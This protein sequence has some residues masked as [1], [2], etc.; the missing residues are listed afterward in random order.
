MKISLKWLSDWIEI[1]D[2]VQD[3]ERLVQLLTSAGFEVEGVHSEAEP[4]K[5]VVM[6][7][8]LEVGAHPN[9][10][11]LTVC[12]VDVGESAARQIVCGAKN[13]RT[14]DSVVVALPGAV[15]PGNFAIK[16]GE[17]RG[18]KS[19]G[20]LCSLA[21][22]GLEPD[23]TDGILIAK[24]DIN[25]GLP[26][27]EWKG[28]DDTVFE[29]KVTPNRV[30]VLSHL[31]L[32]RE[33]SLLLDRPL[34]RVEETVT[35]QVEEPSRL[36]VR[37][38]ASGESE[39]F[40]A[41]EFQ[42]VKVKESPDWMKKRLQSVGQKSINNV[43]DLTN[44]LM[45]DIGQPFHAYDKERVSKKVLNVRY[46][47]GSESL[48]LL[49]QTEIVFEAPAGDE[50]SVL[51]I[52]D[53]DRP[54]ALAGVMG[55]LESSIT[56]ET[57]AIYLE[58]AHFEQRR[59]RR[60][61]RRF[62]LSSESSLRFG[63][64]A[65]QAQSVEFALRRA[66]QLLLKVV[67]PGN[68]G[69][70][71]R[72]YR[73]CVARAEQS[74]FRSFEPRRTNLEYSHLEQRL[75][76]LPDFEIL[77]RILEGVSDEV[78]F[79]EHEISLVAKSFRRDLIEP[80]DYIEEIARVWGYDNIPETLPPL[81]HKPGPHGK[82]YAD[83]RELEE[84]LM[85]C[86]F[87][88]TVHYA[89]V[90]SKR[91]AELMGSA[92]SESWVYLQNPMSEDLNV[93]RPTLLLSLFE[94]VCENYRRSNLKGHLFE[95]APVHSKV[96]AVD[97]DSPY[98]ES[99]R[100]G[101]VSF[102]DPGGLH[103]GAD[104]LHELKARVEMLL[105]ALAVSQFSWSDKPLPNL[106]A[107][108]LLHPYQQASLTVEGRTVGG[109]F[110]VHP[111]RL[112]SEKVRVPVVMGEID[113][114]AVMQRHPRKIKFTRW[115]KNQPVDRDMAFVLPKGKLVAPILTEIRKLAPKGSKVDVF[116]ADVFEG[117]PLKDGDKSVTVAM[118]ISTDDASFQA[119]A[120]VE[121]VKSSVT[122]RFGIERR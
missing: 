107:S 55:G 53:G 48:R 40:C 80:E 3:Q 11:K 35:P 13:H 62:G 23:G 36:S 14:G 27:S 41:Q 105:K 87:S 60:T 29:I 65:V 116:V 78:E 70:A 1:E 59:I 54:V 81:A 121:S 83:S 88:Q 68:Q 84:I 49:D 33:L 22:L 6:G 115:P 44:Y 99:L 103:K 7:R 120:W 94:T 16:E 111:S 37:I 113:I 97:S 75:G 5:N 45:L 21:E 8:L 34:Q 47:K 18:Q 42:N 96:S 61:S 4:Y 46:A 56:S 38:E 2:L 79:K 25:P 85:R 17:I 30:D 39:I 82:I 122:Q 15:L 86:G 31:G 106:N 32:A 104:L 114:Q 108:T 76:A 77:K 64:G 50:D 90:S 98:A 43:V 52:A 112:E 28:F 117:A 95:I 91:L 19:S 12:S 67:P 93:M 24:G 9:A 118:R 89:F 102:G 57:Q 26:F 20:M 109:I 92:N 58:A 101:V 66:A 51:V 63:K 72:V 74:S 100:L 73:P 119:D 10:D 71:I 110:A 69:D